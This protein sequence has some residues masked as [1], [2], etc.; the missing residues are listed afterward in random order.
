MKQIPT[1]S[2]QGHLE[3]E[4]KSQPS[5]KKLVLSAKQ[6]PSVTDKELNM[7][8]SAG[9]I[10]KLRDK[11]TFSYEKAPKLLNFLGTTGKLTTQGFNMAAGL[12][13]GDYN[14]KSGGE[15][16]LVQSG[17]LSSVADSK[18]LLSPPPERHTSELQR[19]LGVRVFPPTRVC[20]LSKI[21]RPTNKPGEQA[22]FPALTAE[23]ERPDTTKRPELYVLEEE[24]QITAKRRLVVSRMN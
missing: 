24:V 3:N 9:L 14:P 2:S 15:I 8:D 23:A 11:R 18:L 1:I 4:D 5:T 16:P 7:S 12:Q 13:T 19:E 10:D 6:I 21:N 17:H 20:E 22:P